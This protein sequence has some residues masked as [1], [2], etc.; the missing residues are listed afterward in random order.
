VELT[1]TRFAQVKLIANFAENPRF[2]RPERTAW[3]SQRLRLD[4]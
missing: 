4:H 2:V 3:L 1:D